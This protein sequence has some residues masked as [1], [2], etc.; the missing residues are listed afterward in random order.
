[1]SQDLW[2]ALLFFAVESADQTMYQQREI[3]A[4]VNAPA[5]RILEKRTSSHWANISAAEAQARAER[6]TLENA[7]GRFTSSDSS[8]VA[9]GS[10]ARGE[11][12][13]GSDLDW[14]L[15]LDG[16]SRPE[17][18]EVARA[19]RAAIDNIPRKQPG[20]EGVFGNLVSSHDLVHHIGG[21]DDSNSNMTLRILLLLESIPIGRPDAYDRVLNNI[22]SRYLDEDRG[23][24][25]GSGSYKVPRFLFNDV[26]RY[27]R[28]MTVDFAYKQRD[29]QNRG[30]A[31]RNLKLRMSRK[32]LFLAG[33]IACFECHTAFASS[34]ERAQFYAEKR[35]NAVIKHLRSVLFNPPLEII[36]AALLRQPDLDTYAKELF[37]AYD[38]F[39]GMLA[40][41]RQLP[42]GKTIRQHLDTLPVDQ[43]GTDS[44]ASSGRDV[45]HRFRDAIRSIFL[46]NSNI[47]GQ[48]TIEYGVF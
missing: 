48:L 14:I 44:I 3:F 17:Q 31:I 15:L 32:L 47:L 39:L 37:D 6:H 5:I 24:W 43:L 21:E 22:L 20:T 19:I 27:W 25:H 30:F 41:D 40:D 4:E 8:I 18:F 11:F 9:F 35:V 38:E 34:E 13:A 12:T 23:L 46:T 29:R 28:T 45:S 16:I 1:M 42:N 2:N 33:M 26:A 36:A 10:L 7:L